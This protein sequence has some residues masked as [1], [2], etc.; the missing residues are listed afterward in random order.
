MKGVARKLPDFFAEL[1]TLSLAEH[2]LGSL[3]VAKE[4]LE[5]LSE[6]SVSNDL[7]HD[8]LMKRSALLWALRNRI[9]AQDH[10]VA[11]KT[12]VSDIEKAKL[13]AVDEAKFLVLAG[14]ADPNAD[15]RKLIGKRI[16]RIQADEPSVLAALLPGRKP[17]FKPPKRTR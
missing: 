5:V 7:S 2:S 6:L 16:R 11:V 17:R 1:L 14:L 12:F 10:Q 13:D 4:G 9:D 15:V 3:S 8:T